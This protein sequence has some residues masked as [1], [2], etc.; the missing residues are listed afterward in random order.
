MTIEE[1]GKV[2]LSLSNKYWRK[3]EQNQSGFKSEDTV[4][5]MALVYELG[6]NNCQNPVRLSDGYL[7]EL[8]GL[9]TITISKSRDRLKKQ[10]LISF[11]VN[12]EVC[13]YTLITE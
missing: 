2:Q 3:R 6:E 4:L 7:K 12:N 10:N 5:Y 11:D 9:G 13:E 8:T 1:I